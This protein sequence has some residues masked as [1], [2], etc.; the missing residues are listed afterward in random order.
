MDQ[1]TVLIGS[2]GTCRVLQLN[3]TAIECIPVDADYPI[4]QDIPIMVDNHYQ[5][6]VA[7]GIVPPQVELGYQMIKVGQQN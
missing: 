4:D 6:A 1:L 3:F 5:L 2:A 7:I